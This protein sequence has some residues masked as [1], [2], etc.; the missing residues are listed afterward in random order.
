MLGAKE[1]R[2][3]AC[4][5]FAKIFGRAYPG[6][7]EAYRT[8]DAELVVVAAGT[9]VSMVRE[10]VDE[11]RKKGK[12]VGLLKMRVFRP[13]PEEEVSAALRGVPH[14]LVLDRAV[15]PGRT[16]GIFYVD[17]AF[18]LASARCGRI[19]NYIIGGKDFETDDVR[20]LL[21]EA[22][23][24]EELFIKWH[25]EVLDSKFAKMSTVHRGVGGQGRAR[26]G[27]KMM[28][29]RWSEMTLVQALDEATKSKDEQGWFRTGDLGTLDEKGY[30]RVTGR[31]KDM[32]ISGGLNVDPV[33]IENLLLQHPAVAAAQV[34]GVPDP[35]MGEVVMAFVIWKK[36]MAATDEDITD[37]CAARIANYKV[38]K[39]VKCVEE[40]PVTAYG[41]VQKFKLREKATEELGLGK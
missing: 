10:L 8:Q 14:V 12:N 18:A 16:G 25:R 19:S 26:E 34:V 6:L 29:E 31:L 27:G 40:F 15:S 1:V 3:E 17:V 38:P 2:A 4:S 20:L 35:R 32:I 39:Y 23:S 11:F 7:V 9:I 24:A 33:E 22:L 37:F 36:D 41:K 5:K 21:E 28:K 13:F 30:L